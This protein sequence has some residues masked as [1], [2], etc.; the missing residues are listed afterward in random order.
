MLGYATDTPTKLRQRA[1]AD[2]ITDIES[3]K[4]NDELKQIRIQAMPSDLMAHDPVISQYAKED[5]QRVLDIFNQIQE[6]NHNIIDKPAMMRGWIRQ[7]LEQDG[8]IAPMD[9]TAIATQGKSEDYQRAGRF[10]ELLTSPGAL[11]RE[12][13]SNKADQLPELSVMGNSL[14]RHVAKPKQLAPGPDKPT[15]DKKDQ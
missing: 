1:L 11:L 12:T 5:S 15:E 8:V 14:K 7:T 3:P 10:N 4:F 2:A 6:I 13:A 9:A